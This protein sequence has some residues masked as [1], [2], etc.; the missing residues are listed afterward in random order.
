MSGDYF[1]QLKPDA[2]PY[3][4]YTPRRTPLLL[5][6]KVKDEIDRL[7]SL[8]V[9]ERDY[10]PTEWCAPIIVAPKGP[11]IRLCVDLSQFNDSVLRAHHILP[12]ADQVLAQ[13]ADAR[14]SAN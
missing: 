6:P 2:Q 8:G 3:A 13:L 1:I 9:I 12:S 10:V 11:V 5:V 4:V 14:V 7:L